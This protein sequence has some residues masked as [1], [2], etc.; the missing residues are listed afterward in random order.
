[1][2][3]GSLRDRSCRE[4]TQAR[5]LPFLNKS[6]WHTPYLCKPVLPVAVYT[7]VGDKSCDS[8]YMACNTLPKK[9]IRWL[10][11]TW[12]PSRQLRI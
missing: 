8:D 12:P 2:K 5:R 1:M 3:R 11:P 6:Y 9:G 7:L 10:L 4:P